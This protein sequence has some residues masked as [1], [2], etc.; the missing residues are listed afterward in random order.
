MLSIVT[1]GFLFLTIALAALAF[2]GPV[3]L[4]WRRS[5]ERLLGLRRGSGAP[6]APAQGDAA[7]KRGRSSNPTLGR[8]LSDSEWASRAEQD[9]ARANVQ[10]RVGEYLLIRIG[11]GVVV[12]FIISLITQFH[13]VG[14]IGG[15]LA[16]VALYML[17]PAFLHQLR[18]RRLKAIEKQLVELL[19]A[20]SSS[21]RAGFAI[22]QGMELAAEQ[23]GPP[24][25]D[26]LALL[27]NDT[28]LGSTLDQALLD[29][30][31]RVGSTDLDMI[32]TAILVQRSSGGNLSEIMDTTAHTLRERE[33][34]RG[35]IQTL[36]ASQ[37]FAG[38]ILSVYPA[39]VGL[40]LL[41]LVPSIWL[42]MFTDTLGQILLGIALGLQLIGFLLIRRVTQIEI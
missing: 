42:D 21:L 35:E 3:N 41:A 30:G 32:I 8:L 33:R 5:E 12:F 36:T 39:A 11:L 28:N 25:A 37:R 31:E 40:L 17:V 7:F 27:I 22:Q 26:E 4:G 14:V 18:N 1:A 9:L 13:I 2:F 29:M 24:L 6:T 38:A 34:I 15:A 20:L 23:L 16:A 10:L 19:P